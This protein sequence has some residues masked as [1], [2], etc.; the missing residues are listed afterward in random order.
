MRPGRRRLPAPVYT[1]TGMGRGGG[2]VEIAYRRLRSGQSRRRSEDQLLVQVGRAAVYRPVVQVA[3][4]GVQRQRRFDVPTA[5]QLAEAGRQPFHPVLDPGDE[6]LGLPLVPAAGDAVRA[7]VPARRLRYVR[8]GPGRLGTGRRA[9]GVG[10]SHLAEQQEGMTR[11]VPGGQLTGERGELVDAVGD[12]YRALPGARR[13]GSREWARPTPSPPS[14]W[15]CP[16]GTRFPDRAPAGRAGGP[17]PRCP[18]RAAAR[19]PRRGSPGG[20]RTPG[21]RRCARRPPGHAARS[22]G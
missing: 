21:R 15:S 9:S 20:R 16:T 4:G 5:H 12:V 22:P 8:V 11:N 19:P 18:G 2:E 14:R 1:A 3:V 13:H 6:R 7:G 10:D 17:P